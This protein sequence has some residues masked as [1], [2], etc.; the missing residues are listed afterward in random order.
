MLR[1]K[2]F[3]TFHTI[4]KKGR[5]KFSSF[6]FDCF[7][8]SAYAFTKKK[9][10]KIHGS[11]QNS[12][13]SLFWKLFYEKKIP[14]HGQKC[15]LTWVNFKNKSR[16]H[17]LLPMNSSSPPVTIFI[18][19]HTW[20]HSPNWVAN[21]PSCWPRTL[22]PIPLTLCRPH[23]GWCF[24]PFITNLGLVFSS[25]WFSGSQQISS[26]PWQR[27]NKWSISRNPPEKSIAFYIFHVF[28]RIGGL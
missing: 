26:S 20:G 15:S 16:F 23:W 18:K 6:S 14:S 2:I 28:Y 21:L 22:T 8:K 25:I 11:W 5:N 12:S 13:C 1:S 19:I 10:I 9:F 4:S 27:L 7:F 24:S 17:D 3:Q